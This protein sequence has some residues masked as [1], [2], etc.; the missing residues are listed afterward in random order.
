MWVSQSSSR[1]RLIS[2]SS[3]GCFASVPGWLV[4][5]L[6]DQ[7]V[8]FHHRRAAKCTGLHPAGTTRR[9]CSHHAFQL[10]HDPFRHEDRAGTC[11]WKFLHSQASVGHSIDY[12]QNGSD[13]RASWSSRWRVQP[14]DR[15]GWRG[16]Q[17]FGSAS[18]VKKIAFTGSTPVGKGILRKVLRR[19]RKSR[20]SSAESQPTSFSTTPTWTPRFNTRC[21]PYSLTKVSFAWP[22][23]AF[24]CSDPFT[25]KYWRDSAQQRIHL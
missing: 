4:V 5:T 18:K 12:D 17:R 13:L 16:R 3:L 25:R 2:S 14:C 7:R 21:S 20:S 8:P 6:G 22:D 1:V 23:R 15:I 9:Y 11:C 19:L 24:S 10:P